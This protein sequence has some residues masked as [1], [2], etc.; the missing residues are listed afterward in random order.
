MPD[1]RSAIQRCGRIN[2]HS[3]SGSRILGEQSSANTAW[4][5]DAE[6]KG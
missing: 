6:A 5:G 2:K 4:V 1:S 3:R